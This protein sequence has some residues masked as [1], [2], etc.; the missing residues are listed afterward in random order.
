MEFKTSCSSNVITVELDSGLET[1]TQ[2]VYLMSDVH[3]DSIVSD[4]NILKK[5]LDKV[6]QEDALIVIGGS[7]SDSARC[8]LVRELVFHL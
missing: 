3:F 7:S 4:R 2:T 6:L 8:V 5:H 1:L